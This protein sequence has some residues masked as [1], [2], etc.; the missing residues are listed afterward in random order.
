[1]RVDTDID[2]ALACG[3]MLARP[4]IGPE[5]MESYQQ[6]G[7][8]GMLS[9]SKRESGPNLPR[10]DSSLAQAHAN[11]FPLLTLRQPVYV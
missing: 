1:M 10:S 3:R 7:A 6:A 9:S 5:M 8:Q 11:R 2:A 4:V